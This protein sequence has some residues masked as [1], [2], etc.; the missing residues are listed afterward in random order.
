MVAGTI[1]I[2]IILD[3]SQAL[4]YVFASMYSEL[5]FS[6]DWLYMFYIPGIMYV[7]T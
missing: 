1:Y 3:L 7:Y 2:T 6:S 5:T 4:N